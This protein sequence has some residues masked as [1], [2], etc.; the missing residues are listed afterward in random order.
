MINLQRRSYQK[1]LMD[2]KDIPFAAIT[3]TLKELNIINTWLGGH[4]ITISGVEQL[5]EDRV[6]ITICEIGCG[7]GDNLFAI[8][9]YCRKNNIAASFI[10]I[11]M[12]PDC[13][14][15]AKGILICADL[16]HLRHIP[17]A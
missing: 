10:G 17:F 5:K 3:Q 15:F 11:D 13:I 16:L 2:E 7:G 9:K 1:E 6:S 8:A 4:A 14:D 12:N